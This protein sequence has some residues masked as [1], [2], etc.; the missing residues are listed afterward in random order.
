[1]TADT[2][3]DP[4]TPTQ[5][6]ESISHPILV[7]VEGKEEVALFDALAKHMGLSDIQPT[8]TG[9]KVGLAAKL[10]L[11]RRGSGFERVRAIGV[12]QDADRD[13]QGRFKSVCGA[14][15]RA[16]L[17]VPTCEL[18][19]VGEHPRVVVL[20]VPGEGR[21]GALEDICLEAVQ[22]EPAM[23]CVESFFQCLKGAGVPAPRELSKAKTRVFL[24][25]R[26]KP[27]L[28]LGVACAEGY[29]P[30][31]GKAFDDL[32]KLLSLLCA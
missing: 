10:E 5:Q 17:P 20:I 14:L 29:W 27:D 30:L 15:R 22:N 24:A 21:P 7:V 2:A 4:S 26:P 28:A 9:G 23:A 3:G 12:V 19:P 32:R 31:K 11:L 25:S 1:M 18:E 16:R 13:H 6:P 8:D